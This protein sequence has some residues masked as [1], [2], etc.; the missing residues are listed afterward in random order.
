[1]RM[2][3]IGFVVALV[4]G[5]LGVCNQALA[6][7]GYWKPMGGKAYTVTFTDEAKH[8]VLGEFK[9]TVRWQ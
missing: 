4:I 1:M 6:V 7:G 9:K 5:V 2:K 8:V 3:K